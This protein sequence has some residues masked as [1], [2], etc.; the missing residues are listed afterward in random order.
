MGARKANGIEKSDAELV[1]SA[2]PGCMMQLQDTIHHA[3]LPQK[4]IH[5]LQLIAD[6]LPE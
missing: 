2:C 3:G 1:A 5:V 6:D 4:V